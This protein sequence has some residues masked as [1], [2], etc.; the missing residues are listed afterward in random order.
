VPVDPRAWRAPLRGLLQ[1][2]A[3]EWKDVPRFRA[4][5]ATG[6]SSGLSPFVWKADVIK[7]L[8][9]AAK[10]VSHQS[11][12]AAKILNFWVNNAIGTVKRMPATWITGNE[13]TRALQR[14]K[15]QFDRRWHESLHDL[16]QLQSSLSNMRDDDLV[17]STELLKE[18]DAFA[19]KL[20]ARWP[21]RRF[22][23]RDLRRDHFKLDADMSY[24]EAVVARKAVTDWRTALDA[25]WADAMAPWEEMIAIAR[26][27][28]EH[29]VPVQP[30]KSI[31][32]ILQSSSRSFERWSS[33]L[34]GLRDRQNILRPALGRL[35]WDKDLPLSAL[36]VR[37]VLARL[38]RTLAANLPAKVRASLSLQFIQRVEKELGLQ[39]RVWLI[40][41]PRQTPGLAEWSADEYPCG[42]ICVLPES[43]SRSEILIWLRGP[44]RNLGIGR[45]C[46]DRLDSP[47]EEIWRDQIN[48]ARRDG[49]GGASANPDDAALRVRYPNGNL[50]GSSDKLERAIWLSFF[51]DYEF[52]RQKVRPDAKPELDLIL[53]RRVGSK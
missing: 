53:E 18:L 15:D 22:V 9:A 25:L 33:P 50:P 13:L 8:G 52:R 30:M 36:R 42:L 29:I 23:L 17:R 34:D 43:S 5:T 19:L 16:I 47:L 21:K 49:L 27:H 37:K 31:R 11:P 1:N 45:E 2:M 48:L 3:Q 46:L 20:G 32:S 10:A 44:Y 12:R 24:V 6:P 7:A 39:P 41:A 51:F 28:G 38:Q 35:R 26:P 14:C 40:P 4:M